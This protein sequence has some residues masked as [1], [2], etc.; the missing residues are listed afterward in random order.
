MPWLSAGPDLGLF[1]GGGFTRTDYGFRKHPWASVQRARGGWATA[2]RRAR[3]EYEGA[4]HRENS[5]TRFDIA[6]RASGIEILRFHGFGNATTISGPKTAYEVEQQQYTLVPSVTF[7][8]GGHGEISG[9]PVVQYAT[10]TRAP[11]SFV[12]GLRPYGSERFG[13]AGLRLRAR[14]DSRDLPMQPGKGLAASV[15]A[16]SFPAAWD[17][18]ETF[19]DLH[20]EASAFVTAAHRITLAARGGGKRVFGR[21]PFHEAAFI[22]GA[23]NLRGFPS[24]RFAGDAAVWGSAE[25]RL[26]VTHFFCI[27][28]GELGVFGLTDAGRVFFEGESED[29]WHT[30]VGG[31]LWI[32]VLNRRQTMSFAIARSRE[33]TAAYVRGGMSF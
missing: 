17:V 31:G 14:W 30:S 11:G 3:L 4:F 28:P 1:V 18:E 20:A 25:L 33:R 16:R 6:A 23:D 13:Q 7:G 12:A 22:G 8:L 26:F 5:R 21:Y 32:S 24:Q 15:E 29:R 27:L 9:G 2:A 10:T 19:T